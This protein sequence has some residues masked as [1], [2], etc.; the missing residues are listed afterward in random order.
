M[1]AVLG[2]DAAWTSTN[3]SGVA[4]AVEQSDGWHL[5]AAEAS[6]Q[7]FHAESPQMAE[8]RPSGSN[9]DA[10]ALLASAKRRCGRDVDLIAIDMP[11]SYSRIVGRRFSDDEVSRA[12]GARHAATLTPS[13]ERPGRISDDLR[14]SFCDVGYPLLTSEPVSQRGLIEVYPHP[15]LIELANATTR[16]PYKAKKVAHYWPELS[17][18][19]RRTRLFCEWRRIVGLLEKEIRCVAEALPIPEPSPQGWGLKPYE[20]RLD[21]VICAWVAICALDGRAK[22]FGDDSSAI[23][24]PNPSTPVTPPET[25]QARRCYRCD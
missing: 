4:L 18:E 8:A 10:A 2:I 7:R 25:A 6:Y 5:I 12:Y 17:T 22:P 21:A 15:A 9:P 23:W 13:R 20:D 24:I 1:R 16:L 14:D 19:E 3:P 11:L